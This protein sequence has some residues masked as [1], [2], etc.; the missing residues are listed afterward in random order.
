MN[1]TPSMSA[2]VRRALD[3]R[4]PRVCEASRSHL[5]AIEAFMLAGIAA[6]TAQREAACSAAH[7]LSGSLGM[8]GRGDASAVAAAIEELLAND[9]NISELR[10]LVD[11]LDTLIRLV[12]PAG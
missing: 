3:E 9:D 1:G 8:F 5:A 11:R 6:T 7:K 4:W 2:A 12:P 10:P